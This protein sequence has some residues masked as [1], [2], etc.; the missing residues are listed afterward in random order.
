[1]KSLSTIWRSLG[2]FL[3]AQVLTLGSGH[4]ETVPLRDITLTETPESRQLLRYLVSCALTE[5]DSVE[6]F[7]DGQRV[8]Y[9]GS[10]GLAPHWLHQELSQTEQHWVSACI[11][12]RTNYYGV[13]VQI[14]MRDL[15]AEKPY[16]R[17]RINT[18]E[19]KHFQL[20][21]GGFFGNIFTAPQNSA[22]ICVSEKQQENIEHLKTLKR[23]CTLPDSSYQA[24]PLT[25][26]YCRFLIVGTCQGNGVES[27]PDG[28]VWNKVIYTFLQARNNE[29]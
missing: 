21:E 20:F 27:A 10:M 13:P 18:E 9:Q 22:Y 16:P 2:W 5:T 28:S 11:Y 15:S 24:N 14:S 17:L 3:L 25:I 19:S 1:M 29:C 8:V 26:S 12:A 4:G 7:T 23:I 6:F